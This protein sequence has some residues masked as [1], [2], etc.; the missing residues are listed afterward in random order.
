[1]ANQQK[2]DRFR[3]SWCELC[4]PRQMLSVAP[5]VSLETQLVEQGYQW[6]ST[7]TLSLAALQL[8]SSIQGIDVLS[9]K[10][11]AIDSGS[12]VIDGKNMF[13]DFG[14]TRAGLPAVF[15]VVPAF[16]PNGEPTTWPT[17]KAP[18]LDPVNPTGLAPVRISTNDAGA[19]GLPIGEPAKG[20]ASD[21]SSLPSTSHAEFPTANL[22]VR[23]ISSGDG[24][25]PKWL[26]VSFSPAEQHRLDATT[27]DTH[28][29]RSMA[30]RDPKVRFA[31]EPTRLIHQTFFAPAAIPSAGRDDAAE[32]PALPSPKAADTDDATRAIHQSAQDPA[33]GAARPA[34][35]DAAIVDW[36][37]SQAAIL[38]P[39]APTMPRNP[40][41]LADRHPPPQRGWNSKS[42]KRASQP[43]AAPPCNSCT[44]TSTLLACCSR[45]WPP[46][47]SGRNMP[48]PTPNRRASRHGYSASACQAAFKRGDRCWSEASNSLIPARGIPCPIR[49]CSPPPGPCR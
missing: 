29:E 48:V 49:T 41:A 38:A 33:Q 44:R 24:A 39:A 43:R 35:H 5:A 6:Q 18:Q 36:D 20:S 12:A 26:S 8:S 2:T 17:L 23:P 22:A 28:F 10:F 1:M 4:E 19:G 31:L 3:R 9:G 7:P 45:R 25:G 32:L 27:V 14:T 15:N 21:A 47:R 13:G 16:S 11:I 34:I 37:L 46:V 40:P 30:A 42:L